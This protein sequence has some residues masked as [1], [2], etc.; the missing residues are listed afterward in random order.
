MGEDLFIGCF[1]DDGARDLGAMVGNRDNAATNTFEL[2]RATCGDSVYMSLQYGGECFCSNT[3]GNGAQY[4]PV[5]ESE[6]SANVE[7]C[8]THSYNCGGTWR[9]AIYQINPLPSEW[10]LIA[11][12]DH[13]AGGMF[14]A[15]TKTTFL[16]DENNPSSS[17]F[18]SVGNLN[19]DEY[20]IDGKYHFR[21]VF[22]DVQEAHTP[23]NEG[24]S[25]PDIMEGEW[26]QTSWLTSGG[27]TGFEA[28][29]PLDLATNPT[30]DQQAGCRFNGLSP[31]SQGATVFDGSPDHGWWFAS[32]GSTNSWHG[33]I[34]AFRGGDAQGMSLYVRRQSAAGPANAVLSECMGSAYVIGDGIGGTE[35]HIGSASSDEE[36]IAMVQAQCPEANGA[37]LPTGGSGGCYCE[38]GMNGVNSNT[39]WKSCR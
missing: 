2:C 30:N 37:T 24:E 23:C 39:V 11:H 5:D 36:C 29:S 12:H 35:T 16:N 3:Y 25:L 20:L 17:A 15:S 6:C 31:S 38:F 27:V 26:T 33:G 1:V 4:L 32:V 13:A 21:L 7:P 18:M 14:P 34:P 8:A 10:E 28:I 19:A 9:Q 22:S